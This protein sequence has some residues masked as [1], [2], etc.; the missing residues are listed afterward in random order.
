MKT[1]K[2]ERPRGMVRWAAD[3]WIGVVGRGSRKTSLY[4]AGTRY[5]KVKK[6]FPNI[7][8]YIW[9]RLRKRFL[10]KR[11]RN[12]ATLTICTD[13]K[14]MYRPQK[15]RQEYKHYDVVRQKKQFRKKRKTTG[16]QVGTQI[17]DRRW[18]ALKTL[19]S[20]KTR[21]TYFNENYVFAAS[22]LYERNEMDI[23]EK[24]REAIEILL[25]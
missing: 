19:S 11:I 6:R 23:R 20:A 15:L 5:T 7:K 14:P 10:T 24:M 4:R 25:A 17:I 9:G 2:T 12:V 1:W 22:W 8:N 16:L 13:G 18:L 21:A 3:V